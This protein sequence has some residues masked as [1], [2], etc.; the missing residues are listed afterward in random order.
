MKKY[1][2]GILFFV[3][4]S[5]T[6][7]QAFFTSAASGNWGSATSWLLVSGTSVVNYPV[8]GD[9]VII[10]NSHSIQISNAAQ[11]QSL[12]IKGLSTLNINSTTSALAVTNDLLITETSITNISAGALTIT[13]NVTINQK[14]TV[15]QTGGAISIFG[16]AF[17]NSPSTT[18]GNSTFNIDAGVF[19]CIGGMTITATT[20]PAGRIAE[21]KI[22]TSAVNIIG[23]LTTVSSNSKISFTGAG[24]LTL[25]GIISIPNPLSFSAGNGRVVYVGIPGNNQ[26]I[27]SLTYNR[28]V[29]TGVGNGAK[30]ISG[31]VIVTDSLV[32]LSDTLQVNGGG[33]LTL[34][35]NA[36]IV[37]T[38]GKLL[39][40]PSFLGAIDIVYNNVQRDTTSLEIPS[41]TNTLRNLI[42]N[43]ISGVTLGSNITLNNKL[44]LQNGEL[45]TDVF[46]LNI[47][48]ALGGTTTDPAIERVN[49]YV[50][51]KI[52]RTIGTSTGVRIFPFGIGLLQGYREYKIEYTTAPTVAGTLS[53]A[54][55]NT[56]ATAQSGLP[57]IDG[58][59]NI[60]NTQPY[61]WQADALAGLSGG[62]YDLTLTAEGAAGI[63]DYTTLRILKRPSA[64]GSWVLNGIAG[65]NTGTNTAPIVRRN[66]MSNF[67]Q[68]VIGSNVTVVPLTLITFTGIQ[69]NTNAI[70]N[71]KTTNEINTSHFDIEKSS[72]GINFIKIGKV[73]SNTFS[74]F[75]NDYQYQE[76]NLVTGQ[77]YYR[78]KMV[79]K[80][81]KSTF[82]PVVFL[83][84]K[85]INT[86]LVYPTI[87]NSSIYIAN[88]NNEVIY[89]YNSV[90]QF[91]RKMNNGLNDISNLI[92]GLYILKAGD[93]ATTIIKQ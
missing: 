16:L 1:L 30:I 42:I 4:I 3:Q 21:L 83:S 54:H 59:V 63:T 7:G 39:S 77:Y 56:A 73:Y 87:T 33:V 24:A 12:T 51:G 27:A 32:L 62:M 68:F 2:L 45:N 90:G 37:K 72:N 18:T 47:N 46:L 15:T 60:T 36:T 61:Y 79:D 66:G 28:L 57:I 67:S 34:N 92:N 75:E 9:S 84:V 86:L 71:W 91:I 19:S 70:L 5:K 6:N 82:S 23:A 35:N 65:T 53:V 43:N 80:D 13:G 22:G 25:A 58:A 8:A 44:S 11:C 85:I 48:N 41:S 88:T 64:G 78:L 38:A 50:S 93:N 49:G 40:I 20:I 74:S 52:N 89:L 55:F 10:Q 26:N 31:N 69:K 17:L 29:I 14:S 81:G 76:N